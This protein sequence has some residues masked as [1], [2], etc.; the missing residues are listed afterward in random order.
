MPLAGGAGQAA[1]QAGQCSE[2]V[3][4]F[5]PQEGHVTRTGQ[6]AASRNVTKPG[7]PNA[8]TKSVQSR[9]RFMGK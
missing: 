3:G 7:N 8:K 4:R 2:S 9:A 1:P 6:S 5:R